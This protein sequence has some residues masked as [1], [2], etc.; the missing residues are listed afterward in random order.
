MAKDHPDDVLHSILAD[1]MIYVVELTAAVEALAEIAIQN[2]T[3]P[4][5]AENRYKSTRAR[6][7]R[8]MKKTMLPRWEALRKR[9]KK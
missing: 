4:G 2:S 1:L 6:L 3:D 8:D 7:Q 9:K 5:A